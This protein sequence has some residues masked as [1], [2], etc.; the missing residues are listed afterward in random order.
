MSLF[1]RIGSQHMRRW[2]SEPGQSGFANAEFVRFHREFIR[3]HWASGGVDLVCLMAGG[4]E[5]ASFYNLV[6]KRI[7]YFY[8]GAT[9]I[10][11]DK[12]LKPGLLGHSLCIED[13]RHH[14]FRYYDFM[15]G[16]ERYKSNL[17]ELHGHL[18]EAS[19]QRNRLKLR[20]EGVARRAR[21]RWL[22]SAGGE[23][24]C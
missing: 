14:G 23:N 12:H 10:E 17:G 16:Y 8:L 22:G 24:G 5:I 2:G 13:Y 20:I 19:L 1:E 9:A 18:V 11:A 6:Y 4:R 7:V 15:G 3:E 21:N